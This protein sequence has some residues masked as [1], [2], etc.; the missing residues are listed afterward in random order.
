MLP[1]TL[2]SVCVVWFFACAFVRWSGVNRAAIKSQ[3]GVT[4]FT[5]IATRC[6]RASAVFPGNSLVLLVIFVG[7]S[8]GYQE[9]EKCVH[10]VGRMVE[11]AADEEGQRGVII[12]TASVAAYEGQVRD[13]IQ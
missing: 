2:L 9:R 3:G 11:T 6:L 12:N 1:G 7:Y 8:F 10:F 4:P 5:R 13:T